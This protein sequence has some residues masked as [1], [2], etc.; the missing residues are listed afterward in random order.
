[1]A[2]IAGPTKHKVGIGQL[3]YCNENNNFHDCHLR[4]YCVSVIESK[5][6][7]IEDIAL[8][9]NTCDLSRSQRKLFSS[10]EKCFVPTTTSRLEPP[11][12]FQWHDKRFNS[13]DF[14]VFHSAMPWNVTLWP[15]YSRV[16]I[17]SFKWCCIEITKVYLIKRWIYRKVIRITVSHRFQTHSSYQRSTNQRN[18]CE[19]KATKKQ[20]IN[21][22]NNL[23]ITTLLCHNIQHFRWIVVLKNA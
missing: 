13:I 5:S 8:T 22:F 18:D 10:I 16:T 14:N 19:R 15:D 6:R 7:N 1:M 9:I 2:I 21:I 17:T 11:Y 23:K 4:R 3:I 12:H 20:N